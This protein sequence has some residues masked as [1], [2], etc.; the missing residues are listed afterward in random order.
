MAG[1]A[2]RDRARKAAFIER[3]MVAGRE[4]GDAGIK[5]L[6]EEM[7]RGISQ[8]WLWD[9]SLEG[10]VPPAGNTQEAPAA[11]P[12]VASK[13]PGP[14]EPSADEAFDPFAFS[15][16]VL[17]KRQGRAALMKRLDAIGDPAQLHKIAEAQHLGIDKSLKSARKLREAI[18]A[19]AEQRL[20]DR[21]AAA[22]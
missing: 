2:L 19:G 22:S 13:A 9:N 5:A 8:I 15:V 11:T 3:L 6:A 1:S 16:V 10:C 17:L 18:I 4:L 14:A 12:P 21:R 20:A 7:A